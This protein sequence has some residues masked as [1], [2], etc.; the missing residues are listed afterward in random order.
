MVLL[1]AI[2]DNS[3]QGTSR[4]MSEENKSTEVDERIKTAIYGD[5]QY[6]MC[7]IKL[8]GEQPRCVIALVGCN[9]IVS[10]LS[11]LKMPVKLYHTFQR[12]VLEALKFISES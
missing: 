7:F 6:R 3:Y 1:S 8:L 11:S 5:E 2:M 12:L 9:S 10:H 4:L